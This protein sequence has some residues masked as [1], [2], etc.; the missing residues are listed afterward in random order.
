[1]SSLN[2]GPYRA[3]SCTKL[4]PRSWGLPILLPTRLTTVDLAEPAPTIFRFD[5]PD[6]DLAEKL[7]AALATP[8]D[9]AAAAPWRE[10][11]AWPRVAALTAAGYRA[12]LGG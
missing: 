2:L 11:T 6:T 9:H 8:S 1:M 7:T 4:R 3:R 12:A 5:R 10:Q